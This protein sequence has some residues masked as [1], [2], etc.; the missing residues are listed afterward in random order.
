MDL[1]SFIG[2]KNEELEKEFGFTHYIELKDSLQLGY[3]PEHSKAMDSLLNF[4]GETNVK[5]VK[6]DDGVVVDIFDMSRENVELN[7]KLLENKEGAFW[8]EDTEMCFA[9]LGDNFFSYVFPGT[10]MFSANESNAAKMANLLDEHK[11]EY[12]GPEN[13]AGLRSAKEESLK[14][15]LGRNEPCHCGSGLKYKKCCLGNDIK[16]T[17]GPKK[18]GGYYGQDRT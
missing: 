1:A 7:L 17:G 11:L 13:I 10:I 3:E 6:T 14:R 2:K 12:F 8:E 16:E 15:K 4:I 18:V 5:I 9:L